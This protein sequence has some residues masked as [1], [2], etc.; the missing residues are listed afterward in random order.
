MAVHVVEKAFLT[1]QI[2]LTKVDL[3]VENVE[4]HLQAPVSLSA[5][6]GR[7][8]FSKALALQALN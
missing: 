7:S 5:L 1:G 8:F 2:A 6:A 4:E 3:L